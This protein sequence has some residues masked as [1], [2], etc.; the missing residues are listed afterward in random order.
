MDDI[1]NFYQ[2]KTP[3]ECKRKYYLDICYYEELD[4][5]LDNEEINYKVE[6]TFEKNM[7][8]ATRMYFL[9]NKRNCDFIVSDVFYQDRKYNCTITSYN[10]TTTEKLND[11][12][13]FNKLHNNIGEVTQQCSNDIDITSST[14]STYKSSRNCITEF[15]ITNIKRQ[16]YFHMALFDGQVVR[17]IYQLQK[18]I[19]VDIFII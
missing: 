12:L 13:A 10:E 14:S 2:F 7:E 15:T 4:E 17:W 5:E 11:I 19:P 9:V 1:D 6:R 16:T 3:E 8:T 18:L